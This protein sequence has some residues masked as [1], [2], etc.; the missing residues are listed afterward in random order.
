VI[1][2]GEKVLMKGN[3]AIGEAAISAGCRYFFGYPI[4]PQS[5]LP[6]YLARRMPQVN[7]VFLQAESEVAAINMVYGA[8]SAG[9]RVMTSSSSPGVSLKQEGISYLA[10]SELPAVICNVM[11]AG[12]GL[13]TI[14]ASQSDYFQAV[15]GGGHGDYRLITLAPDS[16]QEI[17]DLVRLAFDLSDKYRT[18]SII[19][20]DGILGQ[21]MEPVDFGE[22][23][24]TYV[25][26]PWAVS[27]CAGRKA[28]AITSIHID[29]KDME[30]HNLKL[31]EKYVRIHEAEQRCQEWLLEDADVMI[32]AYGTSARI[33]KSAVKA[34]RE[35]GKKVGLFRPRTL[36]PFPE[37]KLNEYI[38]KVKAIHVAELSAGQMVEDVR[39]IN[40]G[41]LPV[42]FQGRMGGMTFSVEDI[43]DEVSKILDKLPAKAGV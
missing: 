4:T 26:K 28:N 34:L 8:S 9:A 6:A 30:K 13:G 43:V 11:R 35:A 17:I 23:Q 31:Q 38:N 10:C 24:P 29:P 1:Y 25:E 27:G 14:Q 15:K 20:L 41:R 33:C 7:G 18:P 40:D 16:V 12:P 37:K 3:E 22:Y 5:E 19:L 39:L 2:L 32:V 42:S 21:M 36:W